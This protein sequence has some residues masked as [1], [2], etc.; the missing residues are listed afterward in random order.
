MIME[1][2]GVGA[3]HAGQPKHQGDEEGV[4]PLAD[5][6]P[7]VREAHPVLPV[8]SNTCSTSESQVA[9]GSLPSHCIRDTALYPHLNVG[10]VTTL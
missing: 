8:H 2:C 5:L 7:V 1:W 3:Y 9:R 4:P 6:L 10:F